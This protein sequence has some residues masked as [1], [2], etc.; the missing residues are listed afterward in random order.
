MKRYPLASASSA[1]APGAAAGAA[2][3]AFAATASARAAIYAVQDSLGAAKRLR[4]RRKRDAKKFVSSALSRMWQTRTAAQASSASLLAG[5]AAVVP[6]AAVGVLGFG[7]EVPAAVE[8]GAEVCRCLDGDALFDICFQVLV[9]TL[10]VSAP[11]PTST[12]LTAVQFCV[13]LMKGKDAEFLRHAMGDT[14]RGMQLEA[15][16][17]FWLDECSECGRGRFETA[18]F[19]KKIIRGE[20]SV[21]YEDLW[22]LIN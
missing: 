2:A 13:A 21:R 10:P 5:A 22:R 15:F 19:M 6:G 3:V 8:V 12:T 7:P 18:A 20:G 11:L 9:P 16:L 14:S 4:K 1:S 17:Q